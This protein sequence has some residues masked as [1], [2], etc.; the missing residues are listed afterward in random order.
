MPGFEASQE[1]IWE[2][3]EGRKTDGHVAR[4]KKIYNNNNLK[5]ERK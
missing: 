1:K 4:L 2:E 3:Q 5:K